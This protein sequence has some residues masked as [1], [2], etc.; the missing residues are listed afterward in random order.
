MKGKK[1]K[2]HVKQGDYVQIISGTH[3]GK[4]GKITKIIYKK[5]QVIVEN[6][7]LKT[8][9]IQPKQEQD[10]GK[11]IQIEAPI[12]SSNVMLYSVNEKT[13]S[14]F[15]YIKNNKNKKQRILIKNSEIIK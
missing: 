3:K 5:Q 14:R 12:H 2:I 7:N 9:H 10:S 4:T 1:N 11:I 8:K 13:A 6:I 15:R